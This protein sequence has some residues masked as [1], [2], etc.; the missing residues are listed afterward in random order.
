MNKTL[1]VSALALS[2]A[3]LSGAA[4]AANAQTYTINEN[5][6]AATI[7]SLAQPLF[8]SAP[9][10]VAYAARATESDPWEADLG[11][12]L[13]VESAGGSN[14]LGDGGGAII[15]AL[16]P[17]NVFLA[18]SIDFLGVRTP[19]GTDGASVFFQDLT[20]VRLGTFEF[21]RATNG[22]PNNG[23]LTLS[24]LSGT[25]QVVLPID[26]QYDN[27]SVRASAVPEAG[28]L[29]LALGGLLTIAGAVTARRRR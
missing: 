29:P 11:F 15:F 28:T 14:V 17:N 26:A 4:I 19:F 25:A 6:N 8:A 24:L 9:L 23:N 12:P 7:G 20:G 21:N 1:R 16:Q 22:N 18:F 13:N 5:F 2:V 27:V 10:T 3:A